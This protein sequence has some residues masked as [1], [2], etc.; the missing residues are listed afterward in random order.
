MGFG[1]D[2]LRARIPGIDEQFANAYEAL[3]FMAKQKWIPRMGYS[4][5][6]MTPYIPE[7]AELSGKEQVN[8][9]EHIGWLTSITYVFQDFFGRYYPKLFGY[10]PQWD[11]IRHCL[12][13][14][15]VGEGVIGDKTDDG[16]TDRNEKNNQ[17]LKVFKTFM[18]FFPPEVRERSLREFTDLQ[19]ETGTAYC[20]DKASFLFAHGVFKR[21]LH[22]EGGLDNKLQGNWKAS[23]QDQRYYKAIGSPRAVD[24]IF[25]HFLDKTKATATSTRPFI[26]G[27]AEAMYRHDFNYLDPRVRGCVPGEVPPGVKAYY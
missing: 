5:F 6:G 14:H 11:T 20:F 3:V 18:D 26:I 15:E 16:T 21:Y 17:E 24:L 1:I 8:D 25:A 9:L 23:E 2:E 10:Q 13:F 7:G 4:K 22:I 12:A 19:N 27:V